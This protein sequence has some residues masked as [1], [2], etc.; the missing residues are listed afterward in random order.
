MEAEQVHYY[1][2]D[3]DA[4]NKGDV[5]T[6]DRLEQIT[7]EKRGTKDYQFKVMALAQ[8]VETELAERG[9]SVIAVVRRE[10]IRILTDEEASE[11]TE[12]LG[13]HAV[14]K[15]HR[16]F[17]KSAAVDTSGFTEEQQADHQRRLL[18]LG[19][20]VAAIKA[21]RKELTVEPTVRTVPGIPKKG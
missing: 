8:R 9:L 6:A 7:S 20:Y 4:L 10:Q 2:L 17:R 21:A 11:H 14:K 1:P 18:R 15:L 13:E 16:G 3:F 19:R 12:R 5:V